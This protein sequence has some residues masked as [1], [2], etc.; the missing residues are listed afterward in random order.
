MEHY[1]TEGRNAERFRQNFAGDDTVYIPKVYWEYSAPAY[2]P[3]ST[4]RGEA[5]GYGPVK[6]A[7]SGPE[8]FARHQ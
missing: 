5:G 8:R 6:A 7:G 2:S 1:L 3:W 4:W